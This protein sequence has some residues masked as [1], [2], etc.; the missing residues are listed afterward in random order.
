MA[1]SKR[2]KLI[3]D[4]VTTGYTVADIGTDH[5]YVPITL[6]RE[7]KTDKAF[8]VDLSKGSLSK[9][10]GNAFKAGINILYNEFVRQNG[11]SGYIEQNEL[12]A[13]IAE[14]DHRSDE[15]YVNK[16]GIFCAKDIDPETKK[17]LSFIDFRLSDGLSAIKKDE[18]ESIVI[19]GMGGYLICDILDGNKDVALSAKEWILS[20]QHDVEKVREYI[21]DVGMTIAF[22]E[23]ITDKNKKYSII[24]AEKR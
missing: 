8:A 15:I 1:I 19:T 23:E 24:R 9:A 13:M 14:K 20:P 4:L 18:A 16:N 6:I 5:G 22:D 7:K 10:A 17:E 11:I 3:T 21:K 2:I 12:S